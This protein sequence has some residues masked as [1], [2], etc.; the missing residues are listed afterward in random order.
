MAIIKHLR[1]RGFT[2][3][4]LMIVVVIIGILA[5]LAI[6]GVQ[7]YVTNSK[8]AEARMA[9]GRMSK[10]AA[11]YFEAE[12]MAGAILSVGGTVGVSRQLCP[13]A[14]TAI[15]SAANA[16]GVKYQPGVA[17]WNDSAGWT[18]LNFS[19]TQP[20]Y[21]A[22]MYVSDASSG[23]SAA[24]GNGYTAYSEAQLGGTT[25]KIYQNGSIVGSGGTLQLIVAPALCE[26]EG[27]SALPTG[28]TKYTDC[29]E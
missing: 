10:D 22:Y 21:F 1:K 7:K 14:E 2:L 25:K 15:P 26:T 23:A 13:S 28:S 19:M 16:E 29:S 5:A 3:V 17:E 24:A 9:V 11:A 20:I 8:S 12:K 18:C 4:E 27:S 6:Y